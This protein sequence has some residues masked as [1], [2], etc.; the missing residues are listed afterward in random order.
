MTFK[1]G[2]CDRLLMRLS[3]VPS[4][5]YS[6]FGSALPFTNGNTANRP[7]HHGGAGAFAGC[8]VALEEANGVA[9]AP[10]SDVDP[11]SAPVAESTSRFS[12]L[13]SVHISAAE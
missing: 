6:L 3:V 2:N 12:R 13:R 7:R 5:R 11:L 9:D 8:A 10:A 4:L 1:S